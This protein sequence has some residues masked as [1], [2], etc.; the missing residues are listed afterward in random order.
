MLIAGIVAAVG[1]GNGSAEHPS[2]GGGSSVSQLLGGILSIIFGV[3]LLM[4]IQK[5]IHLFNNSTCLVLK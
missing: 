2:A 4:G 1:S 3:V 5:V